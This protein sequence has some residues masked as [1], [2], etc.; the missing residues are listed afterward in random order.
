[1]MT[2][3]SPR[4]RS[5]L[6]HNSAKQSAP[7]QIKTFWRIVK[8]NAWLKHDS[9]AVICVLTA[10]TFFHQRCAIASNFLSLRRCTIAVSAILLNTRQNVYKGNWFSQRNI[11]NY[12]WA[13]VHT[14]TISPS[15]VLT[16]ISLLLEHCSNTARVFRSSRRLSEISRECGIHECVQ[17]LTPAW[18]EQP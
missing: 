4:P 5:L 7:R 15:P 18:P 12:S 13:Y 14:H 6:S 9:W 17:P 3:I 16:Y 8:L 2:V 1:M 11:W 10:T